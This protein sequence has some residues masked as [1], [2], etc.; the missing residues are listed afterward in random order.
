MDKKLGRKVIR[1]LNDWKQA[2]EAMSFEAKMHTSLDEYLADR[3]HDI[4]WG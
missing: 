2:E 4:G 3:M 1:E